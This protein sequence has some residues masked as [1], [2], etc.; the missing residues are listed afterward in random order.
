MAPPFPYKGYSEDIFRRVRV[1]FGGQFVADA[2]TPKLW[3]DLIYFLVHRSHFSIS[4]EHPHFPYY[5]F[6]KADVKPE[7]LS[8][9]TPGPESTTTYDLSAGGKTAKGA[10]TEFGEGPFKGLLKIL[11]GEADAWFEEDERMVWTYP[12]DPYKVRVVSYCYYT[13]RLARHALTTF[14]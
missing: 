1:L 12:R 6:Q 14:Y 10:V 13:Q 3:Y 8:N 5:Y 9:P 7:H 2:Q 11:A 4:W